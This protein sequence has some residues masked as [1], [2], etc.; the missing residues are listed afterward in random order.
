MAIVAFIVGDFLVPGM[1]VHAGV[2]ATVYGVVRIRE[3]V[4]RRRRGERLVGAAMA[5]QALLVGLVQPL[6]SRS[7]N[8]FLGCTS[9]SPIRLTG[10]L[11]WGA[12]KK[13]ESQSKDAGRHSQDQYILFHILLPLHGMLGGHISKSDGATNTC[14][15]NMARVIPREEATRNVARGVQAADGLVFRV[16]NLSVAIDGQAAHRSE[17]AA[18][19]LA[20]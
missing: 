10:R 14:S 18:I 9:C 15:G 4:I 7:V 8:Q 11:L 5:R 2:V 6:S 12:G 19:G 1:T 13:S 3:T 16:E 20:S 17:H